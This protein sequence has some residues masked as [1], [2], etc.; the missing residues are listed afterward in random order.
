MR[1]YGHMDY[2]KRAPDLGWR[3]TDAW[4]SMAGAGDK[5]LPNGRADRR[6][7][8][9]HGGRLLQP[10]RRSVAA[11]ARPTARRR[12]TRSANGTNGCA[13]TPLRAP[14][15][16][17]STSRCRRFRPRQRGPAD[18]LVHRLHRLHGGAQGRG[19]QYGRRR[20]QSA[21]AHGPSPARPYWEGR[22]EARLPGRR[23]LDAV[24]LDPG[25]PAQGGLALCPVRGLE[26][27]R[28]KK[29]HV[30]LT[31]IRDSTDRHE[32]FTERAPKLGGLVEFYR[33]PDRV[34]WTPTGIN[35]PDYPKLAQI[36]WQQIGDVNSGA[37][38]PQEAMDRL[39]AEMDQVMARMQAGRRRP[40]N[41]RRLRPAAQRES[42][43]LPSGSASPVRRRPS[44][45]TR[46]RRARP[47]SYDELVKRWSDALAEPRRGFELEAVPGPSSDRP[48]RGLYP[49]PLCRSCPWRLG[50]RGRSPVESSPD[51]TLELRNV[52]KRVGA[53]THIYDTSLTPRWRPA[54][55]SSG[56][57]PAGKTTLMQLMAGLERP[58][59]GEIWFER[60]ERDR[61]GGAEA[62]C[63]HGPPAVHQLSQPM[64]VFENIAS[65][66]RVAR[67]APD[68]IEQA[69]SRG[70]AELLKLAPLLKRRP[71]ELSGGQQQRTAWRAP[72]SRI[73]PTWCCSTSRSPTLDFK[74]REELRDELPRLFRGTAAHVSSSTRPA[75][76]PR[77]C[78]W[79][80]IRATLSRGPRDPVRRDRGRLPA[81]SR[82]AQTPGSSP[83]RR[84]TPPRSTKQRRALRPSASSVALARRG[85][86][87]AG[88][89]GRRLHDRH[90]P[91]SHHAE[92]AQG[93][94]PRRGRP[95][96]C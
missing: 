96:R 74:L 23:L 31:F 37:F 48:E 68:E 85:R 43:T 10:G 58:T 86:A 55:T 4:L 19:Q 29:S 3:M 39:A 80:A 84:S 65:P 53:E 11:A 1:V 83:T 30:G 42:R 14:P 12:S 66:L 2:G 36:W 94:G 45:T 57:H 62:Q 34:L 91:P 81:P 51:M 52:V 41:L 49:N 70:I 47:S 73:Q 7:G 26:D 44:W 28:R 50:A 67:M 61:R 32:S 90:P 92:A 89:A 69:G 33:S 5:G 9:P 88:P 71:G 20:G 27:R 59:A 22:P 25:R 35:V 87:G 16:T 72:W 82:P 24:Q 75:S 95:A 60:Q 93:D 15:A 38:T 77:R 63:L 79:A 21:V 13:T 56:H 40:A 76:R 78:C 17:T 8:H 18:L 46:S 54:S 64:T 6:V